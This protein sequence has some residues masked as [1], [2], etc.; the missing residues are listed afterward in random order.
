MKMQ[1]TL[2][3]QGNPIVLIGGGITGSLSWQPYVEPLSKERKVV[4]PQPV[5][6]PPAKLRAKMNNIARRIMGLRLVH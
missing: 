1:T 5:S 3:G 2:F 4:L 6:K